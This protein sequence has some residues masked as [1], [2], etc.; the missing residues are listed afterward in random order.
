MEIKVET[1]NA[2]QVLDNVEAMI[3]DL[4]NQRTSWNPRP[5]Y[6]IRKVYDDL[7]IFDWWNEYLSK[8]QLE[9]MRKFLKEAIKLGYTGYVCF[10]VGASG[11]ANGMWAHKK[12]STDGY[13]P[14]G[15]C[16]YKS[17][18]SDYNYWAWCGESGKW[19]PMS[20][21]YDSIKTI[22]QLEEARAF[23]E[24]IKSM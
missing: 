7:N 15:E 10:K 6:E 13:S 21:N 23:V 8:S 12:E 9:D 14:D 17:F 16:L 2:Q 19:Y 22:K 5:R 11:C 3:I 20:D 4:D 1:K 18:V 24:Y